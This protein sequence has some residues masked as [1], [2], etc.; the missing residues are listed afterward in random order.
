MVA[1]NDQAI[2]RL[3][4]RVSHSKY[5]QKTAIF[6]IEDDAQDGP[7]HVDARPTVGLVVRQYVKRGKGDSTLYTTSSFVHSMKLLL[8][9]PPMSQY[10]AAAMPPYASF[11]V[12]GCQTRGIRCA[13]PRSGSE[14]AQHG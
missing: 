13:S 3:V 1:N 6:I 12:A 7:Y 8:R 10:D 14:R 5:R 9:L 2:G 4:D 11:D